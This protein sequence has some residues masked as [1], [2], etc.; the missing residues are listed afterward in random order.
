MQL[1]RVGELRD[2]A[3]GD[4]GRRL[5]LAQA[6][7]GEQL[8]EPGLGRRSGS[9]SPR[10]GG[11]RAARPRRSGRARPRVGAGRRLRPA[12][13]PSPAR[14][15]RSRPRSGRSDRSRPP[16]SSLPCAAAFRR[17]RV[18]AWSSSSASRVFGSS[19]L[20]IES[21]SGSSGGPERTANVDRSGLDER[22]G[23]GRASPGRRPRRGARPTRPAIGA[24][25]TCSIFIASR[26]TTGSPAST[27]PPTR[28][29]DGRARPGHRRDE[30]R[31][32]ARRARRMSEAAAAP[33]RSTSGSGA[34]ARRRRSDRRR[35]RGRVAVD[36]EWPRGCGTAS[37]S[38][39]DRS[40]PRRPRGGRAGR[41]EPPAAG[42]RVVVRSAAPVPASRRAAVR[43]GRVRD[44]GPVRPVVRRP[45][46]LERVDAGLAV[47]DDRLADEPAQEPQVRH[48]PED[49]RLV[50]GG[51]QA[52]QRLVARSAPHAMTLASIGS[53]RPPTSLPCSIPASTR[54]PVAGR[55]AQ[56]LD[57][58]GRRQEPVLRVLGVEPDLDR[59]AG[60]GGRRAC[61][62]PSGS[63]AAIRSWSA[64]RSRPVT[65]SV[66]GCSTWRRVFISRKAGS[67]R[68]S[69]RNS[70]VPA[71]D[72]ADRARRASSAASPEASAQR[73]RR[74]PATAS[75]RGPSGAAAGSS[76]RAR[77]GGR[78]RRAAS[79][80]TWISTWRA[81]STKRSRISAVVA[82]R[83]LRLAP[84][85]GERR[86]RSAVGSRTM[87]MPLPPP[88]A[89][90]LTSSG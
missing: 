43:P 54:M 46:P 75:P 40:Q 25:T 52:S 69:T 70:H 50:E 51:G 12:A 39:T 36:D 20:A 53:K 3:R 61:S 77:R 33:A 72:V 22:R 4:E 57:P 19:V 86:R 44:R 59:V 30:A 31:R 29:V 64:T 88:P 78:R 90:G 38:G 13:D 16:C 84:R 24:T 66:T 42:P 63:P 82:E 87:R 49:D 14:S 81:P 21:T 80:R 6:G 56:R 45:D 35:R 37:S 67:P 7:V 18:S 41:V 68:S 10:S 79:K 5:D 8:D 47:A 76:S 83:R 27:S 74:R 28:D 89:A 60:R 9:A 32:A 26:V 62:N 48:E 34:R 58:T 11:R 55:P 71:L 15:G 73:R 17:L 85:R 65:S 1:V 23:A 2:R